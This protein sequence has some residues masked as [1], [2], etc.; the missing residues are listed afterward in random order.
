MSLPIPKA[1]TYYIPAPPPPDKFSRRAQV[2]VYGGTAAGIIAAI[3]TKA[4]GFSVL[5]LNP[6]WTVGGM[7]TNGL[8]YTDFGNEAVVGG[9]ARRFYEDIGNYYEQPIAWA[10]EP[11][12]AQNVFA[13]WLRD[14]GVEV[15]HGFY[16]AEAVR[17]ANHLIEISSTAGHRV[18]GEMFID[19]SYEGDLMKA[20][21]VA[22]FVG[23]EDNQTYNETSNGF[24]LRDQH[25]FERRVDPYLRPGNPASGLVRGVHRIGSAP[26]GT[27]D[28]LVQAYN[29]RLCMT[30]RPEIR[31]PFPKPAHYDER[32]YELLARYFAAGW[33]MDLLSDGSFKKYDD[34]GNGKT[35]TNNAG[36]FASD[37]IG[38]N[39]EFPHASYE[40]RERIY[41]AHLN[42]QQGLFWFLQ[43]SPR[44]PGNVQQAVRAYGLAADEFTNTGNWPM[45]LYIREC[46]RLLGRCVMTERHCVRLETVDDPVGM[47]AYT[48]DSHNCQRVVVDGRV[49]NEG[50]VQVNLKSPYAISYQ[51][52]TPRESECDNLLVPVCLSASHI[53]YGSIRMEPVFM[54]LGQAAAI[55]ACLC[56]RSQ[57]PVQRLP[58]SALRTELD[59]AGLV[60]DLTQIDPQLCPNGCGN[61]TKVMA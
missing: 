11:A 40:Q 25:Q 23:R 44:V 50:D 9:R 12:A 37:F 48:M 38:G 45:Q 2:V 4:R 52:L 24:Q 47:A 33:D 5:L 36:A 7:T 57:L 17:K 35:D 3:E 10:F 20:A 55:A 32:D 16:V 31:V 61:P 58:Y 59:N 49:R 6:G 18:V 60:V 15:T 51:S 21:R 56:L 14:S 34:I 8:G 39:W 43:N 41:Q 53:A 22:S 27:G 29:F 13:T 54:G 1:P 28:Q 26:T 42:Y 46:R 30:R 19:A